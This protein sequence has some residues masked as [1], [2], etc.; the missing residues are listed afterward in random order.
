ML[1]DKLV[2]CFGVPESVALEDAKEY[3]LLLRKAGVIA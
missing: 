3:L 1:A 2:E